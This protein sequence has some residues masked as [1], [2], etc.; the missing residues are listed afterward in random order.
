MASRASR[1]IVVQRPLQKKPWQAA[2]HFFAQNARNKST[3]SELNSS[4]LPEKGLTS[5]I[6]LPG[7]T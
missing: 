1:A 7:L 2:P 5:A 6:I 4:F 3:G